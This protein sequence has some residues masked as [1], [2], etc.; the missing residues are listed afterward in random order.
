MEPNIS[1]E[2]SLS[3]NGSLA[4]P[5]C[6]LNISILAGPFPNENRLNIF[7]EGAFSIITS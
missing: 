6:E 1:L 4:F 5:I 2:E 7:K 3:V